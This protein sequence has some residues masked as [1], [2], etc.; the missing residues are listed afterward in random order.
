LSVWTESDDDDQGKEPK[1]SVGDYK[2][3]FYQKMFNG[4]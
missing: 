4:F 3:N 2:V 1:P